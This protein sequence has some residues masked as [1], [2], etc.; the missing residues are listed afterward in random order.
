[1][2]TLVP[3]VVVPVVGVSEVT[4]GGGGTKVKADALVTVPCV[5]STE[6]LTLPAALAAVVAVTVVG[7]VTLK[8]AAVAVPNKTLLAPVSWVPVMVTLVPP[9]VVP[10]SGA[11]VVM[12]G[13]EGFVFATMMPPTHPD[14][15][16]DARDPDPEPTAMQEL[17]DGQAISANAAPA[18]SVWGAQVVAALPVIHMRLV[19]M[20]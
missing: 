7:L 13:G 8:L 19:P 11:R 20:A 2:V 1:M 15:E 5:V 3:P 9:V 18:G 12:A 4:L 10:E 17:I 14:P 6:T 16:P